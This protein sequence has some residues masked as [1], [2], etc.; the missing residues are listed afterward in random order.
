MGPFEKYL[1]CT[2]WVL[3]GQIASEITMNSPCTHWVNAPSPP[4]YGGQPITRRG[5]TLDHGELVIEFR[6]DTSKAGI[7]NLVP[8]TIKHILV[9]RL[10]VQLEKLA[11]DPSQLLRYLP[12]VTIGEVLVLL[13]LLDRLL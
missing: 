7:D 4:V 5:Q 1:A 9:S 6:V 3:G 13:L 8:I 12:Q 11:V 2:Q 10:L